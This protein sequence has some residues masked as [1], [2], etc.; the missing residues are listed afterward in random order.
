[1]N[2][3]EEA[4]KGAST[5]EAKEPSHVD[6]NPVKQELDKVQKH[7]GRT[8]AEKAAF[9]LK[10]NAERARE[11]GIDP[12]EILGFGKTE[13]DKSTPVTIEMLEQMEKE[14]SQKT[15]LQ[16]ADSI[17]DEHERGL[18]KHYLTH[19]IVSSGNPQE[20]LRLARSM[21][22]SVKNG[23]LL[24]ETV[25]AKDAKGHN[26]S[27]GAPV[28]QEADSGELTAAELPFTKAPWNLSKEQIVSKRPK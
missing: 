22:N 13:I 16:L 12:E 17:T 9:T 2:P 24:E 5:A 18:T 10:K 25:R 20:D 8:E 14:K 15:S 27:P 11:L 23:Q 7:Q 1:M 3:E 4:E 6:E 21:V 28:K 26:A 19:R